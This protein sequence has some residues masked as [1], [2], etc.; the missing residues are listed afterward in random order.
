MLFILSQE[1]LSFPIVLII[2]IL[3]SHGLLLLVLERPWHQG[4]AA[5]PPRDGFTWTLFLEGHVHLLN[6]K[7]IETVN[8]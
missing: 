4:I 7:A 6:I 1:A 3:D 8:S 5:V 2:L